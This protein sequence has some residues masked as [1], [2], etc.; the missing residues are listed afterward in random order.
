[1]LDDGCF[2]LH[3]DELRKTQV[4]FFKKKNLSNWL[5]TLPKKLL[6]ADVVEMAVCSTA[7]QMHYGREATYYHISGKVT[8]TYGWVP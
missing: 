6:V 2:P 3:S 7:F 1:M 4:V 5:M 8:V